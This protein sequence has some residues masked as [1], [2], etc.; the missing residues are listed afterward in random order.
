MNTGSNGLCKLV[1]N[2]KNFGR[3]VDGS[4]VEQVEWHDFSEQPGTQ[5]GS[6]CR[7]ECI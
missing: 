4:F 6:C 5:R 3:I 2:D 1:C 7:D